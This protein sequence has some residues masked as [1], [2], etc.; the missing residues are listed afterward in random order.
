MRFGFR[1]TFA[2]AV[3]LLWCATAIRLP[4]QYRMEKLGRGTIALR[5][6]STDVF[7]SWRL[8]GTDPADLA[9]NLY[10]STGGAAAMKLNA[11]PLATG[12]NYTDQTADLS[13]ANAYFVRPVLAGAEQAPGAAF[14]LPANAPVRQYLSIPLQ[15]PPTAAM[16]DN[17]SYSY[18]PND[19]SVGDLDGDG[20]YEIV[21]K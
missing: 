9:F 20:E 1:S 10:R 17:S 13:Q 7:V 19:C 5:T 18:S 14:T 16:P 3:G 8:L 6:N 4:A 12:T 11:A 2:F 21:V 15:S